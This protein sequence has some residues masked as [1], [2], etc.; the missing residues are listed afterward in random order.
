MVA[1]CE[2]MCHTNLVAI[3]LFSST[4]E[5]MQTLIQVGFISI[6]TLTA[7]VITFLLTRCVSFIHLLPGGK[8]VKIGYLSP[9][10]GVSPTRFH[11]HKLEDLSALEHRV[12]RVNYL[13]L[14]VRGKKSSYLI[15]TNG[16][17][18]NE[19]IYDQTV[20]VYRNLKS[21]YNH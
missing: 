13:S 18:S 1:C 20:G 10:G 17:F 14:R 16:R 5:L 9:F 11:I 3:F 12:Y 19:T 2:T 21:N 4:A 7:V 6:G 8:Q 15:D